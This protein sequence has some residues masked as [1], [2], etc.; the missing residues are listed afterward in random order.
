MVRNVGGS[1]DMICAA[2]LHDVVED[3]NVPLFVIETMFGKQIAEWVKALTNVDMTLNRATRKLFDLR[4]LESS[5][6]Q[7]QTIKLADL[8]DNTHSIV[9][10]DPKF[11]AVYMVEKRDLL[12]AL[13]KGNPT[14]RFR[15]QQLVD[16]YF[17]NTAK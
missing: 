16:A 8:I 12:A 4:R 3:T 2:Y 14:L 9:E 15:A 5:C 17:K 6:P 10:R 13:S 11:A 1:A 7:V